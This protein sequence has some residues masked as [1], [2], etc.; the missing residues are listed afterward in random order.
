M[1]VALS[2]NTIAFNKIQKTSG[3]IAGIT[4]DLY[5]SR[6]RSPVPLLNAL[7]DPGIWLSWCGS[8]RV[9]NYF[10]ANQ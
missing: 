7:Y 6:L 9:G 8:L 2:Y 10:A 5:P 4:T 3:Y 1:G